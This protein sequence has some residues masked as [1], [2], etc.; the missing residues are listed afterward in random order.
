MRLKG[1]RVKNFRAIE[2]LAVDLAPQTAILGGNGCGKSTLLRAMERFFGQQSSM[3]AD[4]FFANDLT[5]V[6]E[7][8][9]TFHEFNGV[10]LDLF[11]SRIHNREMTVTRV[12]DAGGG[13]VNGSYYGST[14]KHLGFDAIRSI[15]AARE[16]TAAY[17]EVRAS[18]Q[19]YASLPAVQRADQ[20]DPALGVWEQ[21]NI[22]ECELGRDDGKFFGFTNVAKGALQKATSFVFVPAVRDV[23][24]D[25]ID[26]KGAVIAKLMELVVRSAIQKRQDIRA[27]QTRISEEFRAITDPDQ[28]PELGGLAEVLSQTLQIFYNEAGVALEWRP[29][30]EFSIPLPAADVF[31][32][33]DGFK[34][35]VDRKG[36]GLQRA[37]VVT[38]LQ[39]LARASSEAVEQAEEE[40]K[41]RLQTEAATEGQ[42]PAPA[43][44]PQREMPGLILAIEEP[45]LYQHPTKQRHFARVLS[46]LSSG[47]IPGVAASTQVI[48]ASHSSLFVSMDRFE[49][50]RIARRAPSQDS[51]VKTCAVRSVSLEDVVKKL[52]EAHSKPAGTYST[53]SLRARLHILGP[54][55][56][57][58][59]FATLVVLVEGASDR[60]AVLATAQAAG[61]DFEALGI[62]VLPVGGKANLDR[63][64]LIFS[65]FGIPVY[66][67]W[68]C[69]SSKNAGERTDAASLNYA[70]QRL[71]N[72]PEANLA[73][74]T[75]IV[76]TR[77]AS[78]E[79]KLEATMSAEFGAVAFHAHLDAV[80]NEYGVAKSSHALKTPAIMSEVMRRAQQQHLD[81]PTLSEIVAAVLRLRTGLTVE[82]EVCGQI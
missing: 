6:I 45:E 34:G 15:D 28:L 80:K 17:N 8:E 50:I 54:E 36:H 22:G 59:F 78:F 33:D 58:G 5:R 38:L 13:R 37:F 39:H 41:A 12:F 62:A 30:E 42:N 47:R 61:A 2:D 67:I 16:K 25:S 56:A 52:E 14:L 69:D 51:A 65:E 20:I 81:S 49:E 24:A 7:I 29:V 26:A 46:E 18:A 32:N 21:A 74:F 70:L 1:I 55:L 77:H 76:G 66:V 73:Q 72:V 64:A 71:C 19:K 57:E 48:F 82:G 9:L 11:N 40:A 75:T 35:P 31:L 63:P 3:Q 68:D 53:G 60:A 43:P 27:F 4:D 79:D 23:S 44:I 10:E